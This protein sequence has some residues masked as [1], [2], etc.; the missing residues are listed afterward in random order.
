MKTRLTELLGIEFP[1]IQAPMA[2][3]STPALAAVVSNAGAL[4]SIG[5]GPFGGAMARQMIDDLKRR[6]NRPYHVNFFAHKAPERDRTVER[7][8]IEELAPLFG[9][10]DLALPER[11]EAGAPSFLN[12]PSQLETALETR[13]PIISFHF[14]LPRA[15]QIRKLKSYGATLMA[16]ATSVDEAVACEA[17]GMDVVIAQGFEAG[18]H[19]G[20]HDGNSDPE[21]GTFALVPQVTDALRIPVVAAGG[22]GDGRGVAAALAL[23]AD[24]V[25]MGTAFIACPET[26]ASARHRDILGRPAARETILTRAV[27]GRPARGFR[28]HLFDAITASK[29]KVPAFPLAYDATRALSAAAAA[30]DREGFEVMLAGQAGA[31]ARKLPAAALLAEIVKDAEARLRSMHAFAG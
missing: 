29:R 12:D 3:V 25:Q 11:L 10:L 7:A 20:F 30:A 8:W 18:G 4:G 26:S 5:A 16:S 15:D 13:P 6:T 14:G 17:A 21:I 2:G 31:L 22:V 19:R 24:G 28:N 27:S 23:G 9:E 1:I